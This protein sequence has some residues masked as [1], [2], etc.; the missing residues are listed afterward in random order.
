ML[1]SEEDMKKLVICAIASLFLSA[2]GGDNAPED[3]IAVVSDA[4]LT[5]N[6]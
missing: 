2:C 3:T 5:G 1:T 6:R 4:D